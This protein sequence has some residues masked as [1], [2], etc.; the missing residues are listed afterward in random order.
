MELKKVLVVYKKSS[1]EEHQRTRDEA[2]KVLA[3]RNIP[4]VFMERNELNKENTGGFVVREPYRG[5]LMRSNLANGRI[6]TGQK[7][8]L[9]SKGGNNVVAVDPAAEVPLRDKEEIEVSVSPEPLRII[10]F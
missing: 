9:A 5:E 10:A 2:A 7:L 4:A 1:S 8:C 3:A 6:K